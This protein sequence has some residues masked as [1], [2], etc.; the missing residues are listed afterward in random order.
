MV[1]VVAQF[2]EELLIR[3]FQQLLECWQILRTEA[4]QKCVDALMI[5]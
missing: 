2:V 4:A 3:V 1:S 5:S